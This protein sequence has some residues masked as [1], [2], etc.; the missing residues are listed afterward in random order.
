M[1]KLTKIVL[2]VVVLV[3]SL[4][5]ATACE[6]LKNHEHKFSTAWSTDGTNHYHAGT[7]EG[8]TEKS[9]VTACAGGKATCQAKATCLVCGNEYG[10]LGQHKFNLGYATE[11]FLAT[12][13]TH[14]EKATYYKSCVCGLK[15]S[16]TFQAGEVVAHEFEEVVNEELKVSDATCTQPATYKL[17]CECGA[18][19][20]ETFAHGEALGHT[21][22]EV[23]V[24]NSVAATC[25][26]DGSYD[27]VV[28]CTV[29]EA[30]V[31][32]ETVVVPAVGHKFNES[33]CSVCDA[34]YVP[35]LPWLL[36]TELKD[37]DQV[38]IGAPHYGKLLSAEK[39]SASSYYN[40]GVNYS[41]SN[42]ANVTDSEIFVVT[43]N[44]DGT[45]T[46]TSLTGKVIALASSYSS[47]NETGEHKSWA[48]TDRGDGTFLVKNTGRGNYLEWYNSMNN[49]ST[50]SAGNTKEYYL[51]FYVK[52]ADYSEEHV[53][54]FV[55][56]RKR[57]QPRGHRHPEPGQGSV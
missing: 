49:W 38:L 53:G 42:F 16:E 24:E 4:V 33:K 3:L 15:G 40:K 18:I 1:K 31:S 9:N 32:R 22:G 7:F 26:A 57:C 19:S 52:N 20:D 27:N 55:R 29:C 6:T 14:T 25:T 13:A 21:E 36:T 37:G 46:F 10:E 12:P 39:V 34:D 2:L 47:L 35:Q 54:R 8:C 23:V 41:E 56:R 30:E 28:N 43:V 50:Y 45:Y 44:E 5:L 11:E 17:S 51:S 48:L